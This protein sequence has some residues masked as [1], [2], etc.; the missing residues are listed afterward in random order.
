M[1]YFGCIFYFDNAAFYI[2]SAA[3]GVV[4]STGSFIVGNGAFFHGEITFCVNTG[5]VVDCRVADNPYALRRAARGSFHRQGAV[6]ADIDSASAAVCVGYG[7][8]VCVSH[9]RTA[10]GASADGYVRRS[11][12]RRRVLL[13][14]DGTALFVCFVARKGAVCYVDGCAFCVDCTA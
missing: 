1:V 9:F 13:C 10:D 14:T 2:H 11:I 6:F 5:T 8:F 7:C 4:V 12:R 3:A